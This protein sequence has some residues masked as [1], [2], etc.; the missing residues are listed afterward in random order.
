MLRDR[1]IH[2]PRIRA[3]TNLRIVLDDDNAVVR[4]MRCARWATEWKLPWPGASPPVYAWSLLVNEFNRF[5]KA[6][7]VGYEALF[8]LCE[9]TGFGE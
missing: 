4:P 5:K 1:V 2:H 7:D 9:R 6:N 3:F 8:G